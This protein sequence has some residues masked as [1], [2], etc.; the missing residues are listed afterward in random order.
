MGFSMTMQFACGDNMTSSR[1][2]IKTFPQS[3]V[4]LLII[5]LVKTIGNR[6]DMSGSQP[7]ALGQLLGCIFGISLASITLRA[8]APRNDKH[9]NHEAKFRSYAYIRQQEEHQ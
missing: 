9:A 1:P 8:K 6:D 4:A 3:Q 5:S 2:D 7:Y